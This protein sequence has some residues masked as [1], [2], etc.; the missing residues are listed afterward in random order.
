MT[1]RSLQSP[2]VLVKPH[3]TCPLLPTTRLGRPG[4]V[5]PVSRIVWPGTRGSGTTIEARYQMLGTPI[6]RCM[7]LATRP[8]P[9]AVC[10]PATAQ[11]L[12]PR[13]AASSGGR[14]AA[15]TPTSAQSSGVAFWAAS[16]FRGPIGRSRIPATAASFPRRTS[17]TS[18]GGIGGRAKRPPVT[19][20][21]HSEPRAVRKSYI[22]GGMVSARVP[23]VASNRLCR[24]CRVLN[25]VRPVRIVS[26]TCQ[27]SG[28][29]RS[30][31]YSTGG[32][33]SAARPSLTPPA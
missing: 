20:A 22:A 5:T 1:T 14:H 11:L 16:G 33:P 31:T 28:S 10:A 8:A 7:S 21:S 2:P 23:N 4:R 17:A 12:L 13:P 24:P 32:A 26:S 18:A 27:R 3:A 30:K 15:C 29:R 25:I 6:A 19:G 9:V